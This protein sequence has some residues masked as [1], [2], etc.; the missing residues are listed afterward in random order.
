[1][2]QLQSA[3]KKKLNAH[4]PK[5]PKSPAMIS[6]SPCDSWIG[7]EVGGSVDGGD[8]DSGARTYWS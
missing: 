6:A 2:T 4:Q 1:M 3:P 8:G 5:P 7:V